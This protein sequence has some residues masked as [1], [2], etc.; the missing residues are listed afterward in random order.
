M[1]QSL[2]F[3]QGVYMEGSDARVALPVNY[4]GVPAQSGATDDY[5]R[6]VEGIDAFATGEGND[7]ASILWPGAGVAL[8]GAGHYRVSGTKLIKVSSTGGVTVIGDV[9]GSGHA[10]LDYSFD[11]LGVLSD[12]KLFFYDGA[13]LTEVTDPNIPAN[14]ID[15]CWVDSFWAVTDGVSVAVSDISVPTTFN[16][17]KFGGTDRPNPVK[18]LL[19]V[20]NELHVISENYVDVFRNIGGAGFPFQRISSAV[21]TKGP[22]GTRAAC[23][24]ENRVAFV[25]GGRNEE[26]SVYLG[27]NAQSVKIGSQ[28]VDAIL[29]GYTTAQLATVTTETQVARGMV[30]LYVHLPDRSLVYDAIMSARQGFPVWHVRV[31]TLNGFEAFRAQNFVRVNDS[32]IVGDP[33]STSIGVTTKTSSKHFGEYVRGEWTTG[34]LRAG[35]NNV[36]M[37]RLT[38]FAITGDVEAGED[39]RLSMSYSNDGVGYSTPRTI[40]TGVRGETM[41]KLEWRKLGKWKQFRTLRFQTDGICR[42]SPMSLDAD[43]IVHNW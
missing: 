15:M 42:V 33:A 18:C 39:P 3:L 35:T 12:G 36:T 17:L 9:G 8:T 28:E 31:S 27:F 40:K 22:I 16:P 20:I 25:G 30:R 11:L 41:K 19:K 5:L 32:W 7:R 34:A 29:D 6:P 37:N 10:R 43:M 26:P 14:L 38:L 21:V 24:F 4:E 1:G 2:P 23:V 13:S